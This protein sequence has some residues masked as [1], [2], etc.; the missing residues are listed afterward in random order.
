MDE[1]K[2]GKT[3]KLKTIKTAYLY[4]VWAGIGSQ[5]VIPAKA[6]EQDSLLFD[7]RYAKWWHNSFFHVVKYNEDRENSRV[8]FDDSQNTVTMVDNTQNDELENE[9]HG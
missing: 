8:I 5:A 9:T 1:R 4:Y 3:K 6:M 2:V 7:S